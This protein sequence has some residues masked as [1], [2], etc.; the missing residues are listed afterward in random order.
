MIQ[1]GKF[2]K[3]NSNGKLYK[4]EFWGFISAYLQEARE[5]IPE[6]TKLPLRKT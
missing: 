3:F 2:V 4:L 5:K 6:K 1:K